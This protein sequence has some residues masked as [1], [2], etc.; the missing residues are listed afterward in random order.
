MFPWKV[1]D[2]GARVGPPTHRP[3]P[4]EVSRSAAPPHARIRES[5]KAKKG[6]GR[7]S[8]FTWG[9]RMILRQMVS[10]LF[11]FLLKHTK[12]VASMKDRVHQSHQKNNETPAAITY[13][14]QSF[15]LLVLFINSFPISYTCNFHT[16][17][18]L[19]QYQKLIQTSA[20]EW[21]EMFMYSYQSN[22][23]SHVV[24]NNKN[25]QNDMHMIVKPDITIP[26]YQATIV[27]NTGHYNKVYK[28]QN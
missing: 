17:N 21:G 14:Q 2:K 25:N 28:K 3:L 9:S 11:L 19:I 5:Q 22:F 1:R 20:Q 7:L 8:A 27:R 18:N 10:T 4:N 16:A 24:T 23:H 15:Q 13:N 6:S 12:K 26:A